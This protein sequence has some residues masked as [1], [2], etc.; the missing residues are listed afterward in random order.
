MQFEIGN[1]VL[2]VCAAVLTLVVFMRSYRALKHIEA[3]AIIAFL[4]HAAVVLYE[5]HLLDQGHPDT[6]ARLRNRRADLRFDH[7]SGVEEMWEWMSDPHQP[8]VNSWCWRWSSVMDIP[9]M[10]AA[11]VFGVALISSLLLWRMG[12]F[13][14]Y[15][16]LANGYSVFIVGIHLFWVNN[17]NERETR[18]AAYRD[19]LQRLDLPCVYEREETPK[20]P[21]LSEN[22]CVDDG[23]VR[24]S[25]PRA[26]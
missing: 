11:C 23:G 7:L 26:D 16:L 24:W 13:N 22:A 1:L 8:L 21:P 9:K 12:G 6:A 19:A 25:V 17:L 5:R 3:E 18:I 10:G 14:L 4:V 15:G 2:V 20:A